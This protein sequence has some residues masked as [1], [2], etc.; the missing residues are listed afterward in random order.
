MR[1]LRRSTGE[2]GTPRRR[3]PSWQAAQW[4]VAIGLAVA[5]LVLGMV[6]FTDHYAVAGVRLSFADSFYRSL[7]LFVLE[8]GGLDVPVPATLQA[9]RLLAPLVAAFAA[10]KAVAALFRDQLDRLWLRFVWRG[11]VVVCGLG[12]EGM[13]LARSLVGQGWKV[14][15]V[16]RELRPGS[17]LEGMVCLAGDAT[18]P[19]V[20]DRAGIGRAAHLVATCGADDTN[21]AVARAARSVG[22]AALVIHVHL[23][24][25]R[26]AALLRTEALADPSGAG[27]GAL[28]FFTVDEHAAR[29]LLDTLPPSGGEGGELVIV[30]FNRFG[31][32]L[33]VEAARR[34]VHSGLP[35]RVTI[36]D[37]GAAAGVADLLRRHPGMGEAAA[38]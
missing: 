7:Q 2:R 18:D 20:L 21:A 29:K 35:G 10:V 37:T 27:R 36:V 31:A 14:A 23:R 9:A 1:R 38:F 6:G 5:A 25:A 33:A 22:S 34:G 19:A 3:F 11:H 4:P 15:G 32:S 28:E 12:T 8:W 24:D 26:L 16:E 30:G 17:R 13:T